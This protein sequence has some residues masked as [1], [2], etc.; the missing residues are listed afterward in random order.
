MQMSHESM[1]CMEGDEGDG[2]YIIDDGEVRGWILN[3]KLVHVPMRTELKV[4]S[5]FGEISFFL[6]SPRTASL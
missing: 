3:R 6:N 1:I 4:G 2:L 5:V